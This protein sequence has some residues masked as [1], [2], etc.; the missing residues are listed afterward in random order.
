GD[1]IRDSSVT[2][3]QTCALPIYR[4]VRQCQ[5]LELVLGESDIG[6]LAGC[7]LG[8]LAGQPRG[9]AFHATRVTR[10]TRVSL[11]DGGHARLDETVRSEERRVGRGRAACRVHAPL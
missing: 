4:Q 2:G 9:Q 11:L 8:D 3:V 5:L 10:G 1:G 7:D 6:E